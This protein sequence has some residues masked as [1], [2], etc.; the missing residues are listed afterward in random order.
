MA[1]IKIVDLSKTLEDA[2]A[3]LLAATNG[4][5]IVSR[6]DLRRMLQQT[7]DPQKARFLEFFYRFLLELENRPRMRVTEEVIDRGIAFIEAQI[8]PEFEIKTRFQSSTNQKIAQ[9]HK[10]ALPMA[11]ELIR[12]TADNV[13]LTPGEVSEQIAQLTAGLF[14]DDYG[15]EAAIAISEFFIEHDSDTLSP[16]SFVKAI[17]LDPDTPKGEVARFENADRA[18]QTF[19]EQHVWSGLSDQAKAVVELMQANLTNLTIIILGLDNHPD[20][21]SNHPVYVIGIGQN[22]NLAGFESVVIW[23]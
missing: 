20:L 13:V 5:G 21:E 14:F 22:G 8:I 19:V 2:R 16:N 3:T 23:T 4:D 11:M 6:A 15:S 18:L 1:S 17:G 10:S 7:A 9:I 12:F